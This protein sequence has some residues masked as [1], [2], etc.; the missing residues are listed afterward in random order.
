[1]HTPI[2][3]SALKHLE[4]YPG[5]SWNVVGETADSITV[6]YSGEDNVE[7][8]SYTLNRC[9]TE[10]DVLKQCQPFL[11]TL[12]SM[13]GEGSA[14][15]ENPL[16]DREKMPEPMTST[17][18]L[19]IEQVDNPAWITAPDALNDFSFCQPPVKNDLYFP[20]QGNLPVFQSTTDYTLFPQESFAFQQQFPVTYN[21]GS[22]LPINSYWPVPNDF[23]DLQGEINTPI[24]HL[25][26][27]EHHWTQLFLLHNN[28][29]ASTPYSGT[30]P[31]LEETSTPS[32]CASIPTPPNQHAAPSPSA[33]TP[34][35]FLGLPSFPTAEPTAAA[36]SGSYFRPYYYH[37]FTA[38]DSAACSPASSFG[39]D[40]A[41][42]FGSSGPTSHP[43]YATTETAS[44]SPAVLSLDG[45]ADHQAFDIECPW[46]IDSV[47]GSCTQS[48]SGER[49]FM[50]S[51]GS[52]YDPHE[53]FHY[54]F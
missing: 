9:L 20:V 51:S 27:G 52:E 7:I 53:D 46:D 6:S 3:A 30:S 14:A 35:P 40:A 17:I 33:S 39:G 10:Q 13:T 8:V 31:C 16:E 4:P 44:S 25:T 26:P 22:F 45:V 38:E 54:T 36:V 23:K 47:L 48:P 42:S 28:L 37:H 50:L 43:A 2:P 5:G 49:V 21:D 12:E 41:F 34:P 24:G 1:M 11:Y 29:N 19:K 32:T 15:N 18:E